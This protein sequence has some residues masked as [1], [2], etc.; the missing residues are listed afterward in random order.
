MTHSAEVTLY[1]YYC[2]DPSA[3]YDIADTSVYDSLKQFAPFTACAIQ[4][5]KKNHWIGKQIRLTGGYTGILTIVDTCG[6]QDKVDIWV[7][8]P[9]SECECSGP[10]YDHI[11]GVPV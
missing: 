4:G 11:S 1:C 3:S 9:N 6:T 5:A 10:K 8:K 2:N 7:G